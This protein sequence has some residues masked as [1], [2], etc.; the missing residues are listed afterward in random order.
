MVKVCSQ[1]REDHRLVHDVRA[2]CYFLTT[3]HC[4]V[5]DVRAVSLALGEIGQ[6]EL[7]REVGE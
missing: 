3:H 2:T 4:L 5:H 1:V 7:Q 6:Q